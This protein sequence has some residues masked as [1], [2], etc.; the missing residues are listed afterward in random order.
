V[1]VVICACLA[2]CST[3]LH[4]V[5]LCSLFS[6]RLMGV[7]CSCLCAHLRQLGTGEECDENSPVEVSS[8]SKH[9]KGRQVMQVGAGGQHTV[10]LVCNAG[11]DLAAQAAPAA[12]A[13]VGAVAGGGAAGAGAGAAGAGAATPAKKRARGDLP[14]SGRKSAKKPSA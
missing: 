10:V 12:G 9:L 14:P 1:N 8:K 4:S 7:C 3:T 13:G 5:S 11:V 6:L 2:A